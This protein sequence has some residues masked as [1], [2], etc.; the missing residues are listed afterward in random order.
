M[1]RFPDHTRTKLL[2]LSIYIFALLVV[3]LTQNILHTLCLVYG[4]YLVRPDMLAIISDTRSIAAAGTG[5]QQQN[6]RD[7]NI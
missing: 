2:R 7:K 5:S 6:K 3:R 1:W 4:I